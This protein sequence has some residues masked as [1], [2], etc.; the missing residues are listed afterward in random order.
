MRYSTPFEFNNAM[1]SRKSLLNCIRVL[2]VPE[3]KRNVDA[4]V[5][6]HIH[7]FA[8]IGF[9]GF[10]MTAKL[11]DPLLHHSHYTVVC[12]GYIYS[13]ESTVFPAILTLISA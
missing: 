1:N 6:S 4:L 8:S 10:L 13:S 12:F 3:F 9:I 7:L 2:T 11:S 5:G